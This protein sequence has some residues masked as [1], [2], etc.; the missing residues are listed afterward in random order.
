[1]EQHEAE[2]HWKAMERRRK[3]QV[4]AGEVTGGLRTGFR[5]FP[6]ILPS[7]LMPTPVDR[8]SDDYD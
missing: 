1:M 8:V 7:I 3:A 4:H 5:F 6:S 2:D